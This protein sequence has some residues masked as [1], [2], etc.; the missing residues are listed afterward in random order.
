MSLAEKE[1]PHS[2]APS[3]SVDERTSTS[4]VDAKPKEAKGG[5]GPYFVRMDVMML[6]DYG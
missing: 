1:Q 2:P 6:E 5:L 4:D 3:K